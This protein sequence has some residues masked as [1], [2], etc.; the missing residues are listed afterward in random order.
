ML[1]EQYPL[2]LRVH[3]PLLCR[4]LPCCGVFCGVVVI[5]YIHVCYCMLVLGVCVD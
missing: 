2:P 3:P 1:Q 5:L 4:L